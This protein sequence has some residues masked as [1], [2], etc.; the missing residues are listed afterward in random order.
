MNF[1]YDSSAYQRNYPSAFGGAIYN[2]GVLATVDSN[3]VNN[4]VIVN[5][6]SNSTNHPELGA[7]SYGGA[8]A[9][10]GTMDSITGI[11]LGNY[12]SANA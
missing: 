6:T 5:A 8:I 4:S 1:S 7:K 9:N 10:S 3:F 2:S 11:F 12:V